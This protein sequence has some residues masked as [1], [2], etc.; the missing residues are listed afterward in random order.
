ME[1]WNEDKLKEVEELGGLFFSE[2]EIRLI[3]GE[4]QENNF[5]TALQRGRLK[6]EAKIR[7][8]VIQLAQSGSGPAQTEAL[9]MIEKMK[10]ESLI[11]SR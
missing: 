5:H 2:D 11:T 7:K 8:S 4:S 10:I 1:T 3:V 6:A 9:K